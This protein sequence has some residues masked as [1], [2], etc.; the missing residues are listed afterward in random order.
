MAGGSL[1]AITAS[2][3]FRVGLS[4]VHFCGERGGILSPRHSD[5]AP[6]G[7]WT[8]RKS[9]EERYETHAALL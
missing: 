7:R 3:E 6:C 8:M 9:P 5:L 2:N 1:E 4:C